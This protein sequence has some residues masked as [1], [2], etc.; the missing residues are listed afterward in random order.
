MI[1]HVAILLAWTQSFK[2]AMSINLSNEIK[3][4]L[5]FYII[6]SFEIDTKRFKV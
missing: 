4:V 5:E 1:E 2:M 3:V 6:L